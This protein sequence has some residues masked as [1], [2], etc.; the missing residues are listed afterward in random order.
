MNKTK[1]C[2]INRHFHFKILLFPVAGYII[3]LQLSHVSK[4]CSQVSLEEQLLQL[5]QYIDHHLPFGTFFCKMKFIFIV[6]SSLSFT[7]RPI[8][9]FI[10]FF[11]VPEITLRNKSFSSATDKKKISMIL[12]NIRL[13]R[14]FLSSELDFPCL[15]FHTCSFF[16]FKDK[17]I[18]VAIV[19]LFALP[20]LHCLGN[21]EDLIFE[22][23]LFISL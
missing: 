22:D 6:F 13:L 20:F 7:S 18:S 5:A 3:L 21:F 19:I 14:S 10:L 8:S 23:M 16:R 2:A 11:Y 9:H 15:R 17:R 12:A 4:Y 1:R